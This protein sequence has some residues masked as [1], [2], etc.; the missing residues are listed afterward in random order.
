MKIS[1]LKELLKDKRVTE[2]INKHLWIESQ[3]AGYSIGTERATDEWFRLY[4]EG[5][6]KYHM[7]EKFR[8]L[9]AQKA[10]EK[11]SR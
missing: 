10:K 3:K 11:N 1:D 9:Q 2:E 4:A 8:Q 7:P 6:M 5:W